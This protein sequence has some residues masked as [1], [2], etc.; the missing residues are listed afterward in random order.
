MSMSSLEKTRSSET[1]PTTRSDVVLEQSNEERNRAKSCNQLLGGFTSIQTKR[2]LPPNRERRTPLSCLLMSRP[3]LKRVPRGT[4][5][6]EDLK[7][8]T[9]T[10]CS[11]HPSRLSRQSRPSRLSA[12]YTS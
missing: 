9:P 6:K 8:R 7:L 11:S 5:E 1:S 3:L 12:G 2:R 4:S 10:S